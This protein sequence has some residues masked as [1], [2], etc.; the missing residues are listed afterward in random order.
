MIQESLRVAAEFCIPYVPN[1]LSHPRGLPA[2]WWVGSTCVPAHGIQLTKRWS[3]DTVG[4]LIL[5]WL[6]FFFWG[7]RVQEWW[8]WAMPSFVGFFTFP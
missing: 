8:V 5:G 3:G 1:H 4:Q 2:R 6:Y 7:R